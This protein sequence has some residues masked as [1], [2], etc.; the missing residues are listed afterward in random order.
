MLSNIKRY[1]KAVVIKTVW[2]WHKTGTQITRRES[3]EVDQ[4]TLSIYDKGA[5]IHTMRK[6]QY[7]SISGVGK[8]VT[9]HPK[10]NSEWVKECETWNGRIPKRK[11]W[12][13]RKPP[14]ITWQRFCK[15]ENKSKNIQVSDIKLL[16]LPWK[17]S[18]TKIGNL[19]NGRKY[20]QEMYLHSVDIQK[21]MKEL[22]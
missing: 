15:S 5:G 12:D 18:A 13:M 11:H 3:L 20:L 22:A 19:L 9:P 2:N 1:Y 7:S 21:Y 16:F 4:H 17:P 6:G 8:H 14:D 10:T